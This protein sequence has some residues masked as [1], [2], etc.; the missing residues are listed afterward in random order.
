MALLAQPDGSI[1]SDTQFLVDEIARLLDA[2]DPDEVY[3]PSALDW[4][5]DHVA[6]NG[7]ARLAMSR[8]PT[9][10]TVLEYPVW[11]WAEGPWR[12][13]T[14]ERQL[15]KAVHL[16]TEPWRSAKRLR[17]E[18]VSTG[19]FVDQKR[20]AIAAHRS[21]TQNLTGERSWATLP[22]SWFEPFLGESEVFF[23]AQSV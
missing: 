3:L 5:P 19:C 1:A 20:L 7:A 17:V 21:Q 9:T 2:L 18:K 12:P 4:H 15:A 8:R 22:Q 13:T 10:A 6:L 16:I 14:D 11:Y 23:R